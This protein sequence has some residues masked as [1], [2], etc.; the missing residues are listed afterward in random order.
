[1]GR[2]TEKQIKVKLVSIIHF[3]HSSQ[4]RQHL[5][6]ILTER[7]ALQ[8]DTIQTVRYAK[9]PTGFILSLLLGKTTQATK[10]CTYLKNGVNGQ[11]GAQRRWR[12]PILARL[13]PVLST[14]I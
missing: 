3:M 8:A 5:N 4:L 12:E 1:M 7:T 11:I 10:S 13:K 6:T 9:I 14:V 2:S